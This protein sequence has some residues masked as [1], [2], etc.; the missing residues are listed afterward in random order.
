[1]IID[2]VKWKNWEQF[3]I[4]FL[5]HVGAKEKKGVDNIIVFWYGLFELSNIARLLKAFLVEDI[6]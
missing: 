3:S 4:R 1:M 6:L 2:E 5:L